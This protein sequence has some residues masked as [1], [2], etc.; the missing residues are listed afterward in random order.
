MT[1]TNLSLNNFHWC[2]PFK[3]GSAPNGKH[4]RVWM[5]HAMF[6][7]CDTLLYNNKKHRATSLIQTGS[8][9]NGRHCRFEFKQ[10]HVRNSNPR[11]S[12][13]AQQLLDALRNLPHFAN[14]LEHPGLHDSA[15]LGR[16][17]LTRQRT[18]P[19]TPA[20]YSSMP[21]EGVGCPSPSQT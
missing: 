4:Y 20:H 10:A 7:L 18:P 21:V 17:Q 13:T 12:Q 2:G 1:A 11:R 6:D 15:A 19:L 8:T 3:T 16:P 14:L 9:P 5:S